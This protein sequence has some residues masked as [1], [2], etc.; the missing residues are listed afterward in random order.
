MSRNLDASA[1]GIARTS[2][3]EWLWTRARVRGRTERERVREGRKG[4]DALEDGPAVGGSS[5]PKESGCGADV[6]N[7][8]RASEFGLL[9]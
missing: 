6:E 7:G 8:L 4:S 1:A 3:W 5:K 2:S 9:V